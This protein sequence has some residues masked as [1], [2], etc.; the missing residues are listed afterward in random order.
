VCPDPPDRSLC[1][2][3]RPPS[4]CSPRA[5]EA[6]PP[7]APAAAPETK[8][9][10]ATF[11]VGSKDFTESVVLGQITMDLLAAHGASVVDK[12]NIKGSVTTRKALTS[13]DVSMYWDYTGTG[14]VSYLGQTKPIATPSSSTRPCVTRT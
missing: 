2:P 13:G 4:P 7:P 12:T 5:A 3:P 11:T 6:P 9:K 10:G 14:W 8:L 1:S